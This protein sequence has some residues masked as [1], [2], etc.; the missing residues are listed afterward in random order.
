[1]KP[2]GTSSG[3]RAVIEFADFRLDPQQRKLSRLDGTPLALNARPFDTLLALVERRGEVLSKHQLMDAVWPNNVVEE[4]NLYQAISVLRKTL[5]DSD[6]NKIILTVPGRGFCFVAEIR[7][8]TD[9]QA[10]KGPDRLPLATTDGSVMPESAMEEPESVSAGRPGKEASQETP[11]IADSVNRVDNWHR[12]WWKRYAVVALV[13]GLMIVAGLVVWKRT[14]APASL[15]AKS[16][17]VLPFTNLS[18]DPEQDYF[19]DGLTEELIHKLSLVDDLLVTGRNSSFYF[20]GRDE[21]LLDIGQ[22]LGV[23]HL[24]QGSVRRAGTQ[25]RITAQLVDVETDATL[26]SEN[27]DREVSDIFVI[28]DDISNAVATALSVVLRAGEPSRPGMTTSVEAYD[29][30]LQG[31]TLAYAFTAESIVEA[32]DH[33]ERAVRLDPQ[34]AR[35]WFDL[36]QAYEYSR[37]LLP[38]ATHTDFTSRQNETLERVRALTPEMP[39]LKLLEATVLIRQGQYIEA[40]RIFVELDAQATSAE[41]ARTYGRFLENVGRS[42]DSAAYIRQARRLEP[43]DADASWQLAKFYITQGRSEEAVAEIERGLS[44][45]GLDESLAGLRFSVA[46]LDHDAQRALQALQQMPV[47]RPDQVDTAKLW[48]NGDVD[49]AMQLVESNIRNP[50][51]SANRRGVYAQFAVAMGYPQTALDLFRSVPEIAPY[52]WLPYFSEL[53]K[54]PDFKE[55]LKERGM[56]AYWRAAG[57]WGDYCRP[58]DDDFECF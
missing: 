54:L 40:E 25:L 4:N 18:G 52:S 21:D 20:K 36:S 29:E 56:P 58:V 51:L 28:Q 17:A 13:A 41:V 1:M 5:G 23:A 38:P 6:T 33:Y 55:L 50:G 44:L 8:V 10:T 47:V 45:E 16:I 26:W 30:F 31:R 9:V 53:R 24:L 7:K 43:L 11:F 14:P 32:I 19:S 48:M 46:L 12:H 3:L 34:F 15:D 22:R 35:A 2:G 39:E 27:F 37:L 42:K 49:G 57:D